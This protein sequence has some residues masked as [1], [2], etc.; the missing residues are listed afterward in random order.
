MVV[1]QV[2][3]FVADVVLLGYVFWRKRSVR[4]V[5]AQFGKGEGF[6]LAYVFYLM[7]RFALQTL[8]LIEYGNG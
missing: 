1:C 2:V 5:E 8:V 4:L 3:E 7:V 6:F